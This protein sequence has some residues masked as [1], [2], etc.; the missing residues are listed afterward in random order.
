[1]AGATTVTRN[2]GGTAGRT[3]SRGRLGNLFCLALTTAI[4]VDQTCQTNTRQ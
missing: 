2:S 4:C 1:V 3:A